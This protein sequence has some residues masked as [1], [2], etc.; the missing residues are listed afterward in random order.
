MNG[1]TGHTLV[2][3]GLDIGDEP[4]TTSR[5]RVH[6]PWFEP[7]EVVPALLARAE[8]GFWLDSS[9]RTPWSGRYSFAGT[10]APEGT[11]VVYDAALDECLVRT[12]DHQEAV[13]GHVLDVVGAW[14]TEPVDD[15]PGV[16]FHSGWVGFLGYA[17]GNF[18]ARPSAGPEPDAVWMRTESSIIFDHDLRTVM[19]VGSEADVART[20]AQLRSLT[21]GQVPQQPGR[22]RPAVATVSRGR[23][24]YQESYAALLEELH[25]GN[26][27]EALLS[28]RFTAVAD[29]DPIDV[30]R[31]LRGINPAPYAAL[32][33]HGDVW[34]LASSPERFLA[35]DPQRRITSKPIKGTLPRGATPEE[36]A[37]SRQRLASEPK[38][39]RENLMIVDLVRNDLSRIC[40]PG[41]VRVPSLMDV[42]SYATVHQLVTTV[43]GV[44]RE[45][46]RTV[47]A[48]RALFPPGSMTGAPKKRTMEIIERIEPEPRGA[49]GG[50]FGWLSDSGTADLAVV[51]RTMTASSPVWSW[52]VGG[53]IIVGSD[54]G[55]EMEEAMLKGAR[56]ASALGAQV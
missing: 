10:L 51:I 20:I 6:V 52:G 48:L 45:E 30:Y 49:Y 56:L 7:E 53:G 41:T 40:E 12:G 37:L 38:F 18:P 24:A 21:S 54:P 16:P 11:S 5:T 8:R 14:P 9:A 31:R 50:T 17:C 36:D 34:F 46:V 47:D 25:A 23:D 15:E 22:S 43:E 19:V 32:I 39:R 27:Y 29:D 44:V 35:V 28:F 2:P 4:K 55:D 13:K 26:T 42:E 3:L 33:R 1:S